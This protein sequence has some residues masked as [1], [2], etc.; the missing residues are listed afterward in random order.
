VEKYGTDRQATGWQYGPC[1]LRA[2][3]LR[4]QTYTQNMSRNNYCFSTATMAHRM[5]LNVALYV[6]YLSCDNIL[7]KYYLPFRFTD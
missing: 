1:A 3:Y 7:S 6:H 4:L 2:G 5:R